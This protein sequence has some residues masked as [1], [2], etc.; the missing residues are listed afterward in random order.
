[1]WSLKDRICRYLCLLSRFIVH[2][3]VLCNY[4]VTKINVSSTKII[5]KIVILKIGLDRL[6]I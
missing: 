3:L 6:A 1:M 5:E 4:V 2:S